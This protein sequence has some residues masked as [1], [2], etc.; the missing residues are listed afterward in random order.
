M[1]PAYSIFGLL[2]TVRLPLALLLV[3]AIIVLQ[4]PQALC[5]QTSSLR[6]CSL[7]VATP[8]LTEEILQASDFALQRTS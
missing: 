8:H 6:T 7:D 1:M 5:L 2:R 3:F 4:P